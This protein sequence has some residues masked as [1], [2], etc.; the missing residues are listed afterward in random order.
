MSEAAKVIVTLTGENTLLLQESLKQFIS[1]FVAEH[2]E[3]GLERLDA[4]DTTLERILEA[5]QV[6]PFLA[7]KRMVIVESTAASK[8]LAAGIDALLDSVPET[9]DLIFTET[10]FDKRSVL[11]KTLKK[12]TDFKEFNELQE[13][14]LISW[15]SA[16]AKEQGGVLSSADARLLVSR[17]GT[18]QLKLKHEVDK[19][20]GFNQQVTKQAIESL[21]VASPQSTT[22]DLLDA[23]MGGNTKRAF[24][25]YADQRRQRVEPQAI[26]ALLGWQLH[27]LAL[28]KAAGDRSV[29]QIAKDS[30]MNPYV[31]RKATGLT[32]R[33]SMTTIKEL[34]ASTTQL[35]QQLKSESID[36]DEALQN[37][38]LTMSQQ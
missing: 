12:R 36:A 7:S 17:A 16:Y 22:F 6:L 35:D 29:D 24:D 10:K 32:R 23:V 33:L 15:V 2:G 4:S 5:V 1:E 30:K 37:L 13:P 11:Y 19:L 28:V 25:L 31:L 3:L 21:V 20:L 34:V 18:N 38:L 26:L 14:Q 9:T 27:I 8:E